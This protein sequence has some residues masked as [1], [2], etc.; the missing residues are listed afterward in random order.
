MY[1]FLLKVTV[2]TTI[3]SQL[4]LNVWD[5]KACLPPPPP[6]PPAAKRRKKP[7]AQPPSSSPPLPPSPSALSHHNSPAPNSST[8]SSPVALQYSTFVSQ[9]GVIIQVGKLFRLDFALDSLFL[10]TEIIHLNNSFT[11]KFVLCTSKGNIVESVNANVQC[12]VTEDHVVDASHLPNITKISTY[13]NNLIA[14]C[15]IRV[16]E[17]QE[18]NLGN[19]SYLGSL[20][21]HALAGQIRQGVYA[22]ISRTATR[23]AQPIHLGVFDPLHDSKIFGLSSTNNFQVTFL[24][25]D[26]ARLDHIL[27]QHWDVKFLEPGNPF[28]HFKYVCKIK[29]FLHRASMSLRCS[30]FYSESDQPFSAYYRSIVRY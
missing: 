26:I 28:C 14:Q 2:T 3:G 1:G 4:T 12:S 27:G 30:F 29:I 5:L 17:C 7:A 18:S 8:S 9:N 6:D 24:G 22:G 25:Q 23:P 15:L 19:C 21:R 16:A 10:C 11:F 20:R 13:V